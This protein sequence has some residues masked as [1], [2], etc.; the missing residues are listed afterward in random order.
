MKAFCEHGGHDLPLAADNHF[1][2]RPRGAQKRTCGPQDAPEKRPRDFQDGS[3]SKACRRNGRCT[4]HAGKQSKSKR[5][6]AEKA[7]QRLKGTQEA[8]RDRPRAPKSFPSPVS[9]LFNAGA[10]WPPRQEQNSKNRKTYAQHTL[11]ARAP[12]VHQHVPVQFWLKVVYALVIVFHMAPYSIYEASFAT[13]LG[14]W[15]CYIGCGQAANRQ[16]GFRLEDT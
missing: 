12:L 14:S 9:P 8:P 10:K 15:R 3:H 2:G 13:R 16:P 11:R 7:Q 4:A 1:Q 6:A 5:E